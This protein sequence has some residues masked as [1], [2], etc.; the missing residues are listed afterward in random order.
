MQTKDN[1]LSIVEGQLSH[2]KAQ[3]DTETHK[4]CIYIVY[5]YKPIEAVGQVY[6]LG[7]FI[8]SSLSVNFY[9]SQF[10][11]ISHKRP[12]HW[13]HTFYL[14]LCHSQKSTL[15]LEPIMLSDWLKF[16]KCSS[17]NCM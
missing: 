8:T 12:A 4:V 14:F 11:S 10:Q 7:I 2:A 15:R 5:C 17:P 3:L 1:K 6:F 9:L 16:Q 13:Y